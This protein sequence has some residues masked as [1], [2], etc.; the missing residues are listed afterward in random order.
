MAAVE[1]KWGS[2]S[3][4]CLV[5]W[6]L[7]FMLFLC[8]AGDTLRHEHELQGE[9]KEDKQTNEKN[10]GEEE[11]IKQANKMTEVECG[12]CYGAGAIGQCCNTCDDV[13]VSSVGRIV[14]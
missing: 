2:P 3:S 11:G 10:E 13:K 14:N 4:K 6:L 9:D 1:K 8:V 5:E 12:N 7:I